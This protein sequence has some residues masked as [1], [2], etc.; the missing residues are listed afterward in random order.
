VNTTTN[1]LSIQWTDSQINSNFLISY[2]VS[3]RTVL[4]FSSGDI[5]LTNA[6][7]LVDGSMYGHSIT[8]ATYFVE[9]VTIAVTVET[10]YSDNSGDGP[11]AMTSIVAQGSISD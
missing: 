4:L 6:M 10:R 5:S 7:A 8:N 1:T 3:A 11:P 9:G 2:T